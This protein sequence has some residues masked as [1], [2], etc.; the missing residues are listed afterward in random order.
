MTKSVVLIHG[1]FCGGWCFADIMPVLAARGWNCQ[2]PDLPF[3][4]S[5][6][7]RTPDPQLAKQSVAD[8]TRDMAA[9]VARF[10]EPPVIVGH[11]MGALIAQQLAAQGLARALVLLAPGAPWGVLPSTEDEM[12]LAKGL[13][14]A[15]PFW[16]KALNPSF[17]VAK[18]DSLASLDPAA[19]RRIFEMFSPE[20]RAGAVRAVLLDVRYAA[21]DFGRDRQ[22]HL[23]G[24]RRI[25]VAGQ[26]H[27]PRHRTQGCAALSQFNVRGGRRPRPFPHYGGGG[28]A[29]RRALRR[30]DGQSYQ[31]ITT[32]V[33]H[34]E[35][36]AL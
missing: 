30:V 27:I 28:S 25:R 18:G 19:Q 32:A 16:D 11:S 17:E 22:G 36:P 6:P 29:T 15:S 35:A 34:G 7:A 21:H 1:A 14:M 2:A 9:F 12:T 3:H 31:A 20:F 8:Y 33:V 24:A 4:V 23:P 5:G 13:M 26:G 10:P